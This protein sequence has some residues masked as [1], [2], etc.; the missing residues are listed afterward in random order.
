MKLDVLVFAAHPDDAEL[1]CGGTLAA[2]HASRKKTGIADL[3][4]GELGTRGNAA[5]RKKESL[6]AAKILGVSVREN[7]GMKDGLFEPSERNKLAIVKMI[8]KYKPD[9]VFA[10]AL[11]DRHPDHSRAA[12]L[13]ADACFLSGLVKI[14]TSVNGKKQN[15][16]RPRAVYH[17]IQDRWLTPDFVV[18]ISRFMKQ[19]MDAIRAY[20]SQFYNPVS[21]EP[22]TPISSKQFLDSLEYRPRELGRLSGVEFAEGFQS[23][24]IIGVKNITD[25]F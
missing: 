16:W 10:N 6:V 20:H 17:Y 13:V 1:S 12:R 24:K 4:R 11:H 23:E 21:P 5:T 14:K 3:T 19:R 18:D 8:R 22:D 9:I 25:L 7:L 2:L 15:A